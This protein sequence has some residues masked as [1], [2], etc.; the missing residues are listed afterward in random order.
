MQ[1][2]LK[3]VYE[4]KNGKKKEELEVLRPKIETAEELYKYY[5][6]IDRGFEPKKELKND[7]TRADLGN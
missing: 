4:K 7:V 5:K 3:K 2:K 6:K 1:E